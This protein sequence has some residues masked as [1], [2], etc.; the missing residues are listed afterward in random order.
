M[1]KWSDPSVCSVIARFLTFTYW[2]TPDLICQSLGYVI[3]PDMLGT[4]KVLLKIPVC[5]INFVQRSYKELWAND[6][7]KSSGLI[8]ITI[9]FIGITAQIIGFC[10]RTTQSILA[11]NKIPLDTVYFMS[12]MQIRLQRITWHAPWCRLRNDVIEMAKC[13]WH[14]VA[15]RLSLFRSVRSL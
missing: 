7:I 2:N 11:C 10:T 4:A 6:C 9:G 1:K 5:Q 3:S 12:R 15:M 13:D 14:A 8:C